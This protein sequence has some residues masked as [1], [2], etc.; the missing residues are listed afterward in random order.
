MKEA[1]DII[2]ANMLKTQNELNDYVFYNKSK[3]G[4]RLKKDAAK[5]K[6]ALQKALGE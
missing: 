4:K 6:K 1:S 2:E 5:A 3:A